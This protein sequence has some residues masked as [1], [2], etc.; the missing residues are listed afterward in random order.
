[1]RR[2]LSSPRLLLAVAMLVVLAA[3]IGYEG[4]LWP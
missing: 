3:V 4:P 2:Y 1:M